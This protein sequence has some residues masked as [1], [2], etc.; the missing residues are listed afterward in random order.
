MVYRF[1]EYEKK[2]ELVYY[3]FQIISSF[4]FVSKA[5]ISTTFRVVQVFKNSR[6]LPID[7][8]LDMPLAYYFN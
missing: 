7:K 2:L 8:E 5:S 6:D 4:D 1:N 3:I